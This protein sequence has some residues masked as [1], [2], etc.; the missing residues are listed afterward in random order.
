M[1]IR[2]VGHLL[3]LL[4][5]ATPLGFGQA[6]AVQALAVPATLP[7]QGHVPWLIPNFRTTIESG[8]YTR[9]DAKEKFRIAKEDTL[10]RGTL[11]LAAVFA[12]EN[13]LSRS[14]PSFG[15]GPGACARYWAT[16]YADF[17]V[18][19]LMTEGVLPTLLHQDP[20]YFRRGSGSVRAR[21]R[22]AIGQTFWTRA[23]SGGHQ[24]NY[25]E[26]GGGR[27]AFDGL[28]S[29]EPK[30]VGRGVATR[31]PGGGRHGSQSR[32]GVLAEPEA[33]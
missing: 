28:Q 25:S 7:P 22:S 3:G 17:A 5:A 21:L 18:G 29:G 23:D 4:A 16:G 20:R 14:Q 26:I 12:G 30:R 27:G 6:D 1:G 15:N 19:N 24:F 31:S 11:A 10:D 9:I 8:T 13:Q 32:K 2:L 33:P